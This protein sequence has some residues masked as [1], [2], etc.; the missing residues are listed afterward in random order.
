MKNLTFNQKL[1][2]PLICSLLC[3]TGIAIF[4]AVQT[5]TIRIEERKNDLSNIDNVALNMLKHYGQLEQSGALTEE[6]AQAGAIAAFKTMTYGSDGYVAVN[7]IAGV[8]VINPVKPETTGA[9]MIDFKDPNGVYLYRN[10]AAIGRTESGEGFLEYAWAH[11]GQSEPVPKLGRVVTYKPWQ[12]TLITGVYMDDIDTAF[13]HSLLQSAL[14]LAGVSAVL[15]LIVFAINRNLHRALGG[16][17]EYA[18]VIATRIADN[19]LRQSVDIKNGDRTSMLYAMKMMQEN[20][21]RTISE[22]RHGADAIA[23]A[24]SEIADGSMDL[25]NRTESQASTLEETAA[26]MEE[27]SATVKQNADSAKQANQLADSAWLSAQQGHEIVSKLVDSMGEIDAK[28]KKI[29]DIISVIDGIAF[30]TNILALNAAVEAARAGEQGRGFAVVAT[31]VRNLSKR[32]ADAAR[33]IKELIQ[34]SNTTVRAGVQLTD[35]VGVSMTAI[36]DGAKRVSTLIAEISSS[37]QEQSSGIEQ[38]A[39]AVGSMDDVTQKNAA[40]VEESTAAANLLQEQATQLLEL[41]SVF[42]L[43][44]QQ[45][46]RATLGA[47][48]QPV[49]R[50]FGDHID[51]P[52]FRRLAA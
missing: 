27:L 42:E 40:L 34:D 16:A 37:G 6:Q 26:S 20:L 8:V 32:S 12:W 2:I 23:T 9:N 36:M 4:D 48:L 49:Q 24:S 30:Q 5:R 13:K 28:S 17:P 33:E 10:M 14:L 45:S 3:I 43:Q 44:D 31:E 18:A 39:V 15:S 1:W 46:Q 21:V 35:Q 7:T 52:E 11:P 51:S 47:A 38:V 50:R 22:I 19:D 29:G 25:S 41:V